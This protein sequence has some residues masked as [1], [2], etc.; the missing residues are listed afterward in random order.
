[1]GGMRFHGALPVLSRSSV[2]DRGSDLP[3]TGEKVPAKLGA[4]VIKTGRL[5][6]GRLTLAKREEI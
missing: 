2:V 3:F 5:D 4:G 6:E 1:M